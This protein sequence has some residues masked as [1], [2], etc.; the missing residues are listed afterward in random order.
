M[1][2]EIVVGLDDSPSDKAALQWAAQQA[3][4]SPARRCELCIDS[5]A[6]T[7]SVPRVFRRQ[8]IQWKLRLVTWWAMGEKS[9]LSRLLRSP[10]RRR[11]RPQER[12][13]SNRGV[14]WWWLGS[15]APV[16]P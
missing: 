10:P 16:K 14:R 8:S 2:N 15:M 12:S 5:A 9:S 1:G 11:A 7:G 6:R 4:K 3:R 13:R